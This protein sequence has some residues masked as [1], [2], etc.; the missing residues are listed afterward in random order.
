MTVDSRESAWS[1]ERWRKRWVA[2][3][4]L[5]AAV[6]LIIAMRGRGRTGGAPRQTTGGL[7]YV[8]SQLPAAF[9]RRKIASVAL[10]LQIP[11]TAPK[12][13]LFVDGSCMYSM[14]ELLKILYADSLVKA[15]MGM[16]YFP[17][18]KRDPTAE[19]ETASLEC[20]RRTGVLLPYVRHRNV[21]L[22]DGRRPILESAI[23]AG[24]KDTLSFQRCVVSDDV[25]HVLDAH[26]RSISG[27]Q[28]PVLPLL[29]TGDSS[30]V[31]DHIG[32]FLRLSQ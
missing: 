22:S 6:I 4:F 23:A 21:V 19:L 29:S 1:S 18:V 3:T 12:R 8:R 2:V 28:I 27:V 31:G 24:V 13:L 16:V 11:N 15:E 20:A 9:D 17:Q 26:R 32:R 30:W 14:N 5:T 7:S 10:A 25:R